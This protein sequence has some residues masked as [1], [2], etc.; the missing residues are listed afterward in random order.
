MYSQL[1]YAS[2]AV[3]SIELFFIGMVVGF[4]QKNILIADVFKLIL[5]G[6]ATY[7]FLFIGQLVGNGFVNW[8]A[9]KNIWYAATILFILGL[10]MFY[11]MVKLGK[12]KQLI[13][14]LETKGL[15]T[16][17]VLLGINSFFVGLV[18]GLLKFR[19][20]MQFYP[21]LFLITVVLLGYFLGF[22]SKKILSRRFEFLSGL[23]Y[24]LIAIII[25]SNI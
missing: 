8:F 15:I 19:G 18:F 10:K 20:V 6:W 14:P 3:L 11:D 24:V 2:L 17:T 13:N 5:A 9:E 23:I 4:F 21:L 25:V 22:K 12:F 1:F 7:I 16:L